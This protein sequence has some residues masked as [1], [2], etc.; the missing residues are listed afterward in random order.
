MVQ[1][2]GDTLLANLFHVAGN[3]HTNFYENWQ[4]SEV[5]ELGLKDVELF[6]DTLEQL[7]EKN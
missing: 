2:T 5:V 3:L 7:L 4:P 1:E 6:L